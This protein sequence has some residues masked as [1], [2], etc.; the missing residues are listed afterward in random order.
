MTFATFTNLI[1][2]FLCAGVV[3]QSMRMM[4]NIREMKSGDLSETVKSLD[5]A[6][7]QARGVLAELKTVLSTDG[8]A[9]VK[10]IASGES[11]RDELSLMVGIGNAVADRIMEAA[12]AADRQKEEAKAAKVAKAAKAADAALKEAG[13]KETKTELAAKPRRSRAAPAKATASVTTRL[14]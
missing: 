8:A 1:V 7:A 3:L 4:R 10:T 9:N 12:A 2:S 13:I 14:Q 6:T 5:R 11:L